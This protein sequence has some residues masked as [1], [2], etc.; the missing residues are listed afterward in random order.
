MWFTLGQKG[1]EEAAGQQVSPFDANTFFHRKLED[2]VKNEVW[3][4]DLI[5]CF[6]LVYDTHWFVEGDILGLSDHRMTCEDVELAILNGCMSD[7]SRCLCSYTYISVSLFWG[8][9]DG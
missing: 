4:F 6:L 7:A 5:C 1:K 3:I 9:T 8:A 2:R